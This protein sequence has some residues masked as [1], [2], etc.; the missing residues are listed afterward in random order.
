MRNR[1]VMWGTP[2]PKYKKRWEYHQHLDNIENE[3]DAETDPKKRKQLVHQFERIADKGHW[4]TLDH[5]LFLRYIHKIDFREVT[6]ST[7]ALRDNLKEL[8]KTYLHM[9]RH[10]PRCAERCVRRSASYPQ[11]R[12]G[13]KTGRDGGG[14]KLTVD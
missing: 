12:L 9:L 13:P 10:T 7:Q 5:A 8:R 6:V 4:R 14:F 1:S 11:P 3:L 2:V